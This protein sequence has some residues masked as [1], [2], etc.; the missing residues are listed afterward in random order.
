M[1]F[2]LSEKER[3]A[4]QHVLFKSYESVVRTMR[5]CQK[6]TEQTNVFCFVVHSLFEFAAFESGQF[7]FHSL[8]LVSINSIFAES[9][10]AD[11]N[12]FDSYFQF[13]SLT[14]QTL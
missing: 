8:L 10:S 9:F 12:R 13:R 3:E 7:D 11:R 5:K 2:L 14:V 1:V 6:M 4:T